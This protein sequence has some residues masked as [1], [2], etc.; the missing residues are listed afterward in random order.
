MNDIFS[1]YKKVHFIGVGGIGVSAIA[2]MMMFSGKQVSG[3]DRA[4]SE[5]TNE[6]KKLGAKIY[7]GQK[8]DN[9]EQ[10]IDLVIY[11]IAIPEDNPELAKYWSSRRSTVA[12]RLSELETNR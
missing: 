1:E 8:A 4:E 3:S 10:G 12:P 5:I 2:R 6:L 7:I 11:T 9:L